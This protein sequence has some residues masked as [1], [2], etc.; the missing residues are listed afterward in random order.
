MENVALEILKYPNQC[1][2][3]YV[4]EYWNSALI[5]VIAVKMENV[6]LEILKYLNKSDYTVEHWCKIY[7]DAK[8]K[9]MTKIIECIKEYFFK[10]EPNG[11][12]EC[13][14]CC[15][16]TNSCI[17]FNNCKHSFISC[18]FCKL[19]LPNKCPI[20]RKDGPITDIDHES[21]KDTYLCASFI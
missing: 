6:A 17:L 18:K 11:K 20:C 13:V 5:Y 3:N 12:Y 14:F 16:K 10:E 21:M 19:D 8:S 2:S 15:E 4:N 9:N 1:N 7:K